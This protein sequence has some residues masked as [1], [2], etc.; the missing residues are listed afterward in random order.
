MSSKAISQS[1]IMRKN[2]EAVSEMQRKVSESRTMQGRVSDLITDFSGSMAFVYLHAVWFGLWVLLNVGKI[3]V[4]YLTE[5][6]PY[7]FGLL[8]LVVSLEAIFLSTFVLISQNRLACASEKR[9]ELD[10][11][12]NLLAEQ[13][14]TKVIEML[15]NIARELDGMSKNFNLKPDPE[16]EAL[17]VSP[18]PEEVLQVIESLTSEETKQVKEQVDR[19]DRAV[20]DVTGEVEAV[21]SNVRHTS[22]KLAE[23]ASEVEELKEEI[24][25]KAQ[26]GAHAPISLN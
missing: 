6:D 21:K 14:T 12:V 10:L 8:T 9:A 24:K 22:G 26:T 15:D 3:H 25:V 16:V 19:V 17:K 13:K 23:V 4:P 20:A 2:I 5:F 18:E 1:E 7:P 11:Q